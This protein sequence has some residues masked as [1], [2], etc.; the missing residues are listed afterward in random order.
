M[1]PWTLVSELRPMIP[2]ML[3]VEEMSSKISRN[4]NYVVTSVIMIEFDNIT[5]AGCADRNAVCP[6]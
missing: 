6:G 1:R 5:S 3:H 2:D 4:E